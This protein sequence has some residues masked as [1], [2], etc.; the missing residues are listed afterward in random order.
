[1]YCKC[2]CLLSTVCCLLST[3][4]CTPKVARVFDAML[5][6]TEHVK[7]AECAKH[8][9]QELVWGDSM[10]HYELIAHA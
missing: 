10:Q 7:H 9:R 4:Y 2:Y 1:M 6:I 8:V 5:R 3:N